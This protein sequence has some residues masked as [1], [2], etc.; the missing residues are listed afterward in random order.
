MA[1]QVDHDED[2]QVEALFSRLDL[3]GDG[4]I[5]Q[6]ELQQAMADEGRVISDE[7]LSALVIAASAD[8]GG[9]GGAG[10]ITL[11]RLKEIFKL[12]AG[13]VPPAL[14]AYLFI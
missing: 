9:G 1:A 13:E 11:E 12:K 8:E 2:A 6:A 5:T 3:S 10:G 4:V 14:Q 7:E